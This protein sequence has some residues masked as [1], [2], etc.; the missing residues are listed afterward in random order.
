MTAPG[1]TLRLPWERPPL[2]SNARLHHHAKAK[3]TR[4]IRQT[5]YLLA[6][7]LKLRPV[8]GQAVVTTT[9]FVPDNRK[10]D[11]GAVTPTTKAMIDGLVDAGIL[12]ADDWKTVTEERYRIEL[13]R[14]DPRI[15]ITIT[16]E[17]D[18]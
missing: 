7:S 13:D 5:T 15:E 1:M 18:L 17:E 4:E 3:L 14:S 8:D 2:T 6:M 16:P 9:W 11:T 12:A 10:R